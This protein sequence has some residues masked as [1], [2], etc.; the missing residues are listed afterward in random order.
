MD[1]KHTLVTL[2]E[3]VPVAM[4][5]TLT[6]AEAIGLIEPGMAERIAARADDLAV[7][8]LH[9]KVIEPDASGVYI[10]VEPDRSGAAEV[11]VGPNPVL[12][13]GGRT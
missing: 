2:N 4:A 9:G 5:A 3:V 12:T 11:E 10:A 1:K 7:M 8:L 6:E 13:I